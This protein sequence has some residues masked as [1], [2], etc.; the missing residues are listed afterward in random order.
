MYYPYRGLSIV[1]FFIS[2]SATQYGE[3]DDK[4]YQFTA[5]DIQYLSQF[6]LTQLP[7]PNTASNQYA[8]N[9]EAA[10]LGHKLFF[11]K[12]LSDN[13]KI[14]CAHCHQASK[15]FTDGLATSIGLS[16]TKRNAP[17][18]IGAV[19]GP[20][21]YWDGRKDS[22]WSQALAPI[23][24][25]KEHGFSREKTA[26]L[27][28]KNYREAYESVFGKINDA[29]IDLIF[30]NVGKAIM[31]YQLNLNI[32]ASPFDEFIASLTS[33]SNP[34]TLKNLMSE[35][36]VSG[37]RLFV[38]K[39][40]CVS[41]HNGPLF[42]NFEFHNVGVPESSELVDLGRYNGIEL[43][44]DDE[45][46]CLSKWSD[47]E[48]DQCEEIIYLKKQGQELIG[49][50]KTPSLRNIAMTAP[51]MHAGQFATLKDVVAHYNKPSPPVFVR[52]QHPARPHFD[53]LPLNLSEKEQQQLV[54]F[55]ES[56]T[57]PL[58]KDNPWWKAPN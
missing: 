12:N 13:R 8:F 36:Q 52:D 2:L 35:D 44:R 28:E 50:F 9:P 3:A 24:D 1:L 27:I 46:N 51:Y 40:G 19:Y 7:L 37:L 43:L 33:D 26:A 57:S 39:A 54:S 45:F 25:A 5:A 10:T 17:T 30:A 15:Y 41:C 42:S 11:D 18:I 31:A 21:K 4:V 29:D 47:A 23:Q 53:I 49:A 6:S 48:K 20:W 34:K 58:P 16:Q 38:G 56:L 22:L 14:S 55:L 32:P